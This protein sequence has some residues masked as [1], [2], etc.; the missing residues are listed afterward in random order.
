MFAEMQ[1]KGL[2]EKTIFLEEVAITRRV[3][4]KAAENSRNL[5]GSGRAD[6]IL[7]EEDLQTCPTLEMCLNGRLM[8]VY[9]RGGIPYNTRG[10]VPMQK[11]LLNPK[12][13]EVGLIDEV[14][15]P[16]RIRTA[17]LRKIKSVT[18]FEKNSWRSTKQNLRKELLESITQQQEAAIDQQRFN[19]LTLIHP[20]LG[21]TIILRIGAGD[22]FQQIST[23]DFA[24]PLPGFYPY[25]TFRNEYGITFASLPTY[26]AN[27][28]VDKDAFGL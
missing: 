16:D 20:E 26:S 3:E 22:R 19:A 4:K 9:F 5:N 11:K 28:G 27:R 25:P 18:Q 8:G 12:A 2:L 6:Q 7:T 10:N 23:L 15:D 24:N 13:L 14:V 21:L 1:Q 17:A